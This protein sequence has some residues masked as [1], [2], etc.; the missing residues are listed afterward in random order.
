MKTNARN[1]VLLL[2][3][4]A[5]AGCKHTSLDPRPV[6]VE[7]SERELPSGLVLE[8]RF[9]GTGAEARPEDVVT[10]DYEVKLADGTPV[11]STENRGLP[12]TVRL[13]DAPVRGLVEGITGMRPDGRRRIVVPP[14]L[15]YGE[16]G[17]EG[18]VPPQATLV[19]DVHLVSIGE[20][21]H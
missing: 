10:I 11:D 18:L 9:V 17:V 21:P 16:K 1:S 13:A 2:A 15:A 3:C 4:L 12:L 6:V 19:F 20:A 14:A 8:D 7:R 5:L